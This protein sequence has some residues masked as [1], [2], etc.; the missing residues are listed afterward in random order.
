MLESFFRRGLAVGLSILLVVPSGAV[1]AAPTP[2]GTVFSTGAVYL[3]GETLHSNAAI[4]SGDTVRTLQG[5]ATVAL[6]RGGLMLLERDSM[7][8]FERQGEMFAVTLQRGNLMLS[9]SSKVPLRV[10]ADGLILTPAGSFP[11]LTEVAMLGDGSLRVVVH[12]GGMS[13]ANLRAEPVVVPAGQLLT[14]APRLAQA[15]GEGSKPIGTGAHGK[16]TLGE[17]L[18]T[19]RIG[20]LSHAASVGLVAGFFGGAVATAIAIPLVVGEE[21]QISPSVP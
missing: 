6:A 12:Q 15:Q 14:V 13:V 11:S 21:E 2:V 16:M 5:R 10:D 7:A 19:F 17:K 9:A 8:A 18:R 4:Y 1:A 20:G 3:G